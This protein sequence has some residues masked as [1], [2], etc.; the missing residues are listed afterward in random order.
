MLI[1]ITAILILLFSVLFLPFY[2]SFL[3]FLVA[4][5]YFSKFWEGTIVFLI[6]DLLYGIPQ[7]NFFKISIFSFLISLFLLFL[8][9]FLKKKFKFYPNV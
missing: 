1:R 6:S 4:I 2:V 3:L 7:V 9:E 5:F 8:M